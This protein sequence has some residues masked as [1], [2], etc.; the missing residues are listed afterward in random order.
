M[1][2]AEYFRRVWEGE[3]LSREDVDKMLS[4]KVP[5][6]LHLDYKRGAYLRREDSKGNKRDPAAE[7]RKDLSAFCNAEGG[8]LIIGV[9]GDE[10]ADDGLQWE[11]APCDP[12]DVGKRDGSGL[13]EWAHSALRDL[14]TKLHPAPR[15]FAIG[16]EIL[17][18]AVGRADDLVPVRVRGQD[19][20][21]TRFGD[22]VYEMPPH[23]LRDLVLGRRA[24]PRLA[25]YPGAIRPT[26]DSLGV[27]ASFRVRVANDSLVWSAGGRWIAVGYG[28]N[29]KL[30]V[31]P[32][33][34]ERLDLPGPPPTALHLTYL[35]DSTLRETSP[36]E[37]GPLEEAE[38]WVPVS[39]GYGKFGKQSAQWRAGAALFF[40]PR[41]APILSAQLVVDFE[42]KH[43]HR[44]EGSVVVHGTPELRVL[45]DGTRPVVFF[46]PHDAWP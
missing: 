28:A 22:G 7:L 33:L 10:E 32:S 9:A 18:I 30:N 16:D 14:M 37:I 6:G 46:G 13:L 21:Y 17:I 35:T 8:M 44:R 23:L 29:H 11:V 2:D 20:Y 41:D 39:F 5:E 34:R 42:V 40:V 4:H 3:L 31:P 24:R 45:E 38:I 27:A 19:K 36:A 12:D 25:L 43:E 26:A 1:R 15:V